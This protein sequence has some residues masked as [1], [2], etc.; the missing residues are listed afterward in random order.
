M[1]GMRHGFVRAIVPG[2]VWAIRKGRWDAVKQAVSAEYGRIRRI[3][4]DEFADEQAGA[5]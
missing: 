4:D 1:G 2:V 3:A 5:V